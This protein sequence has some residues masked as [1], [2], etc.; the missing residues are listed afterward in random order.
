VRELRAK[1]LCAV[2][3]KPGTSTY[4]WIEPARGC[5]KGGHR[6]ISHDQMTLWGKL[7][8][9]TE[10]IS[11]MNEKLTQCSGA[12]QGDLIFAPECQKTGLSADQKA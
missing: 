9:S 7:I 5:E 3:S 12:G 1:W 8:V 2:H 4:C 10:K 6:E 11:A